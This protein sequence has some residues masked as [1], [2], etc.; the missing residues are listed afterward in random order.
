MMFKRTRT[1]AGVWVLTFTLWHW[2]LVIHWLFDAE[3]WSDRCQENVR[4]MSDFSDAD[5]VQW[6]Y[7]R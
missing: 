1:T 7:R 5:V 3:L 4:K 2:H 6:R